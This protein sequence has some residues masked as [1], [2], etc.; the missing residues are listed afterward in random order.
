[1]SFAGGRK[2]FS[3]W[4]KNL[5]RISVDGGEGDTFTGSLSLNCGGATVSHYYLRGKVGLYR[6][7]G[8]RTPVLTV[9]GPL[10]PVT[11]WDKLY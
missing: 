2:T 9:S 4:A 10:Q 8:N 7:R 6:E 5:K 3:F 11:G 1:M